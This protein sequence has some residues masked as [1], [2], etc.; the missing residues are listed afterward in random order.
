LH[1]QGITRTFDFV[2]LS[3]MQEKDVHESLCW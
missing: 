1:P 2:S 3:I